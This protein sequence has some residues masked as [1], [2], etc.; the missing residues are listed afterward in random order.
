MHDDDYWYNSSRNSKKYLE[1]QNSI[2]WPNIN[3]IKNCNDKKIEIFTPN[4][5][6]PSSNILVL[7]SRL[8]Y[9]EIFKNK[10]KFRI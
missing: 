9:I 6:H 8:L 1:Y 7:L 10:P 4:L 5:F 2:G 3:I